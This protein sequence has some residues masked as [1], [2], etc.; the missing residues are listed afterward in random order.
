M[1]PLC[2]SFHAAYA[3]AHSGV[4]CTTPWP[5]PV[6]PG[7]L[8]RLLA[9][10]LVP[11]DRAHVRP[12]DAPVN[13][14]R[15]ALARD[16]AGA[17][18]FFDRDAGRLCRIHRDGGTDL[19]PSACRAFPRV[20][21]RDGRGLSITLSHYCPTAARLLL[22]AGDIRIVDA[23]DSLSLGGAVEGLDATAV[24]PPLLRPGMLMDFEGYARW[25]REGIALLN[26]RQV[27][28]SAARAVIRAATRDICEWSPRGETLAERVSRAFESVKRSTPNF[29]LPTPKASRS[30]LPAE[31]RCSLEQ[32]TKAFLAAHLFA[33]WA[34]YQQGGLSAVVD[35]LD[36][37]HALVGSGHEDEGSFLDAVRRA[38]LRLRHG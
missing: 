31:N 36:A 30:T 18:V 11:P 25:E 9:H 5:V 27:T 37:A 3:C 4:C 29:Q 15:L 23:P 16:A 32:A 24:L 21:L 2:L 35:T 20:A 38:D 22:V 1:R 26:D 8:A 28:A 33:S 6:E 12:L 10:G 17:C 14:S 13:G 7:A 19:L 34:A